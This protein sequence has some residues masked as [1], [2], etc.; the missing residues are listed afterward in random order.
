MRPAGRNNS[1]TFEEFAC[2]AGDPTNLSRNARHGRRSI[3]L[4]ACRDSV[5]KNSRSWAIMNSLPSS[6]A[7]KF[8]IVSHTSFCISGTWSTCRA[9]ANAS[10][11]ARCLLVWHTFLHRIGPQQD[12]HFAIC[13][14]PRTHVGPSVAV[15]MR[16]IWSD[17]QESGS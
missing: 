3:A 10:A 16:L 1:K 9:V 5:A 15:I 13:A 17:H 12:W 2:L 14:L 8:A 4:Q 6:V 7:T 11:R